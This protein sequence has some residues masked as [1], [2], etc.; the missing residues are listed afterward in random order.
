MFPAKWNSC[1]YASTAA[2][3]DWGA[4]WHIMCVSN[5]INRANFKRETQYIK[6]S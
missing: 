6:L 1:K 5:K 3:C 2:R 4:K